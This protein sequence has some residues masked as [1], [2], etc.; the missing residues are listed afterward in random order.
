MKRI[1]ILSVLL[2]CVGAVSA[3]VNEENPEI[4]QMQKQIEEYKNQIKMQ[5]NQHPANKGPVVRGELKTVTG[6]G[7]G[8]GWNFALI[9]GSNGLATAKKNALEDAY[10]KCETMG[11]Q[12]KDNVFQKD[13]FDDFWKDSNN[14]HADC[15]GWSV[16]VAGT[17]SCTAWV[18]LT[19]RVD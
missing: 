10:K 19:C 17:H 2:S 5:L 11:G 12:L 4:V 7:K 1:V 9:L 6:M 8:E 18:K 15:D 13:I 3:E 16:I 14:S